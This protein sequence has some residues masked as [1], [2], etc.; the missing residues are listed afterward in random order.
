MGNKIKPCPFCGK[1]GKKSEEYSSDRWCECIDQ[2]GT[3]Y[4][5]DWNNAYWLKERDELRELAGNLLKAVEYY[6]IDQ[7]LIDHAKKVLKK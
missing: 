1:D 7:E 2:D 6:C 3:V 5:Q 4:C